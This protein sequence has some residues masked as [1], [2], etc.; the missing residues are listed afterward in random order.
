MSADRTKP[1]LTRRGWIA[2]GAALP[3]GVAS[4]RVEGADAARAAPSPAL[5]ARDD[6]PAI[7]GTYL[8]A[9]SVHPF[10]VGARQAVQDYLASRAMS[11]QSDYDIAA[12]RR[13]VIEAYGRLINAGPH[14]LAYVQSTSA[15]EQLAVSALGIPHSGGRIVTDA[16]HFFGSFHL[17]NELER[18]GMEVIVVRPR[19]N[20]IHIEDLAAVVNDR[21]VLVAVSEVSTINGFRHDLKAVAELAHA[22]G[23]KV[24]VDAV[25]ATGATPVDVKASGVDLMA[26]SSYKWLMG[27]MGLGFMYVREDLIGELERPQAGYQQ[28]AAL[29]S[30]VFPHD[31]PGDRVYETRARDDATGLFAMGTFSNTGVAHLGY[32]LDWLN[33]VGVE[34]IQAWRQPMIERVRAEMPRLG[35]EPLSPENSDS[36]LIAFSMENARERLGPRLRAAGV[37]AGLSQH[38]LRVSVGVFNDD[39]DIDRL[40]EA[41]S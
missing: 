31:E 22:H 33:T 29:S 3:L 36:A 18:A 34:T 30:H 37:Q 38:R 14:E 32:S 39:G 16:L 17:Y 19:D 11:G 24:Y 7:E 25:H 8:N 9:G 41:L 15:G 23:A 6:F 2:A 28:L 10:S 5:P 1:G 35:F 20:R 12:M 40:F 13:S 21:T 27:D 26:S 4:A